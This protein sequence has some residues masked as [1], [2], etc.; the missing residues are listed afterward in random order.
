MLIIVHGLFHTD[1]A[2]LHHAMFKTITPA[3][4]WQKYDPSH[5][6]VR[7]LIKLII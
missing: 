1:T 4:S 7:S 3:L 5:K 2:I 6:T